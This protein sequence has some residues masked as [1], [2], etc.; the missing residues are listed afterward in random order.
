M[1]AVDDAGRPERALVERRMEGAPRPPVVL[2]LVDVLHLDGHPLTGRPYRDRREALEALALAGPA[3]QTP[4]AHAG[5]GTALLEAA[6][7]QGLR[8]V[9]AKRLDST[10]AP[11]TTS[12]AWIEVMSG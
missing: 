5:A 1:V 8:G 12:D 11:G 6:R 2:M 10:Y 7:A 3:W 9:V 4:A